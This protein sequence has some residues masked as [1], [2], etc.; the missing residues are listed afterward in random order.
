M[1]LKMSTTQVRQRL[2]TGV[3]LLCSAVVIVSGCGDDDA[4]SPDVTPTS[5]S[6]KALTAKELTSL[7]KELLPIVRS[8]STPAHQ[9]TELGVDVSEDEATC[10]ATKQRCLTD[11][12]YNDWSKA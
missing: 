10:A 12:T 8:A 11:K 9:C 5:L 3:L 2:S 1:E 4:A 7:C 6:L